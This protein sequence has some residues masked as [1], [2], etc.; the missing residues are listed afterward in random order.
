MLTR[1]GDIRDIMTPLQGHNG[2]DSRG[3]HLSDVLIRS[4]MT[5]KMNC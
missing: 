5:N 4:I 2:T 1:K 3:S